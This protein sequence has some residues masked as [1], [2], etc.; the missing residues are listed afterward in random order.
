MSIKNSPSLI[1][2]DPIINF[3]C[4]DDDESQDEVET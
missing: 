3:K 1:S 4:V 2:E